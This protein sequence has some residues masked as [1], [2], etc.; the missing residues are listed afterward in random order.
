MLIVCPS[1]GIKYNVPESYL[2]K[3]RTLK[4]A[5]CGTSWVVP[6]IRETGVP[7]DTHPSAGQIPVSEPPKAEP[8]AE[9]TQEPASSVE[10]TSSVTAPVAETPKPEVKPEAGPDVAEAARIPEPPIQEPPA[11]PPP[12]P[13][14]EPPPAEPLPE[15]LSEKPEPAEPFAETAASHH[16]FEEVPEPEAV[17][18]EIHLPEKTAVPD[19]RHEEHAVHADDEHV[20]SFLDEESGGTKE[21]HIAT[22]NEPSQIHAHEELPLINISEATRQAEKSYVVL[23]L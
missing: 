17:P 2:K 16:V 6:A 18:P 9:K 11:E 7:A 3:D 22:P 19:G 13:V 23:R 12:A 4:C 14:Q 21:D 15:P 8:V 10:Q 20:F 5:S 1:C